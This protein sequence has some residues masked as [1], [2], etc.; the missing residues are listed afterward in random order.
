M[1]EAGIFKHT[2]GR[3][4][5]GKYFSLLIKHLLSNYIYIISPVSVDCVCWNINGTPVYNTVSW[6]L[7]SFSARHKA[8]VQKANDM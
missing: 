3:V 1:D 6:Y 4:Y 2:F 8:K 5:K 7:Y